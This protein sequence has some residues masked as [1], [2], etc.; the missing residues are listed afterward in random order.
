MLEFI[1]G[2]IKFVES[3]MQCYINAHTKETQARWITMVHDK[4]HLI[5]WAQ[6]KHIKYWPA[7]IM[8]FDNQQVHVCF[9]GGHDNSYNHEDVPVN[10]CYLYSKKSPSNNLLRSTDIEFEEAL[11]VEKTQF[12][13]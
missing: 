13:F 1:S 10:K 9:F 5:I 12:F 3:C 4:P 8:S 11:K 7:K 2:E 6:R